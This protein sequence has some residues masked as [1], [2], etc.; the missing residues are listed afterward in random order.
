MNQIMHTPST[1]SIEAIDLSNVNTEETIVLAEGE[2]PG[3]SVGIVFGRERTGLTNDELA[4]A[5]STIY[6]PAN[7]NYSVLN[8]A[9]AVNIVG[10]ELFKRQLEL[11]DKVRDG[12]VLSLRTTD[13]LANRE[14]LDRFLSRLKEHLIN[15]GY[16]AIS[17][18]NDENG[19]SRTGRKDLKITKENRGLV[20]L[21][22]VKRSS[23]ENVSPIVDNDSTDIEKLE[24]G[25]KVEKRYMSATELRNE[26][27]GEDHYRDLKFRALQAIFRRVS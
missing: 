6:I 10:Y 17:K 21:E 22:N 19:E 8:L 11:K 26:T 15:R 16:K 1:A 25:E 13:R 20:K 3:P 18:N 23:P 4:L 24:N 27:N 2:L 14:E 5:D 9:Q 7:E 12:G